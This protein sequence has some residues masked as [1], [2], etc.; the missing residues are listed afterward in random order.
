MTVFA[1]EL[2]YDTGNSALPLPPTPP[3]KWTVVVPPL[4]PSLLTGD[5]GTMTSVVFTGILVTAP[6]L[7]TPGYKQQ[8]SFC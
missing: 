3:F 7:V 8:T 6:V 4:L 2:D 5:Q 1:T